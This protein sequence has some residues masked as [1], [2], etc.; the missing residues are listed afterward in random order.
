MII[1]HG[2]RG[3]RDRVPGP[4]AGPG[5]ASTTLLGAWYATVIRWRRPA[6]LFV[7][8]LTLLPLVMPLAPA[9]TLLHRLP[10]ALAELLSAHRV[11]AQLI[12]VELA[13][14]LE[15]RLAATA[16]RSLV[17]VMNEFA[18]LADLDR[19][20]NPDLLRMSMRLATT[21]CGPLF[22]RHVSPD[23]ELAALITGLH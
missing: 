23:R 11:P 1:V 2:T 19:A 13:Q 14:A 8:E 10:D 17:G 9:K 7:N 12:E 5:D 16:N 6:A 21:P 18:Y 3:F 20:E 4:A 15:H 22:Q